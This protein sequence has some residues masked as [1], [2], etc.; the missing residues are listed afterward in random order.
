[1][2]KDK[3]H[4]NELTKLQAKREANKKRQA[5]F[6]ASKLSK[7]LAEVRG[8]Y[9]DIKLHDSIKERYNVDDFTNLAQKK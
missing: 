4:S 6:R 1:M 9:A 8:I 2:N 3:S 5:K 7:N